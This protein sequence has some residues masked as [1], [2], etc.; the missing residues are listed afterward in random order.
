[1]STRMKMPGPHEP[2]KA[3]SPVQA[4]RFHSLVHKAEAVL[5]LGITYV[6]D[7]ALLTGSEHLREA[8]NLLQQAHELRAKALGAPV[9]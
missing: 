5:N 6:N 8:A 7:G 2:K 9:N 4:H 3:K 1:M